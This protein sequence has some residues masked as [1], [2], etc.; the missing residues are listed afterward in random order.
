M[1]R[2]ERFFLNHSAAICLGLALPGVVLGSTI[3]YLLLGFGLIFGL[4]ATKGRSLRS[5]T[6]MALGS[7]IFWLCVVWLGALYVSAWQGINPEYSI[8]K[9]HQVLL[10]GI[11]SLLLFSVLREMPTRFVNIG[12]QSLIGGT[13]FLML[14]AVVDAFADSVRFSSVLHGPEMA[15][16]PYRLNYYSSVFAVALP[17]LWAFLYRN[18]QNRAGIARLTTPFLLVTTTMAVIIC[19]GRAGWVALV[20]SAIIFILGA[21]RTHGLNLK[22]T[23]IL[24][25]ILAYLAGVIA[26]G[27]VHGIG[28]L[29]QRLE[30]EIVGRGLASGRFEIWETAI[31]I[32]PH[33]WLWGIGPNAFRFLEGPID[34]HPHNATLQIALETG[35]VGGICALAFIY[36]VLRMFMR[37]A[38]GNLFGLAGL[39]SFVTFIVAAQ[40][41]KSLFDPEWSSLLIIILLFGWRL[42]W[43]NQ[44][45]GARKESQILP[46]S[47]FLNRNKPNV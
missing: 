18:L 31:N 19:G 43:S 8:Y 9:V 6:H 14:L 21:Q 10:M 36:L 23:H 2:E 47:F 40:F 22:F 3:L 25:G 29:T 24:Y 42:G 17:F 26:Y 1:L 39:T 28:F 33:H 35:L 7:R 37:Y 20:A 12:L 44:P 5:T 30:L 16:T 11:G 13:L 4:L 41:N 27:L 15:E 32:I 45:P 46:T 38:R 34:A